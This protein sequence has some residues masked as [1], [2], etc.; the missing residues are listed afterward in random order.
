MAIPWNNNRLIIALAAAPGIAVVVLAAILFPRTASYG[1]ADVLPA[2]RTLLYMENADTQTIDRLGFLLPVLHTMT[3]VG[4]DAAAALIRHDDGSAHWLLFGRDASGNPDMRAANPATLTL[5]G[6][7]ARLRNDAGFR[8]L[9][10]GRPGTGSWIY[11]RDAQEHLAL[12]DTLQQPVGPLAIAATDDDMRIMWQA[13]TMAR[14]LSAAFGDTGSNPVVFRLQTGDAERALGDLAGMLNG[15]TMLAYEAA[16]RSWFAR[17]FGTDLSLAYDLAPLVRG[18]SSVTVVQTGSGTHALLEAASDRAGILLD[19]LHAGATASIGGAQHMDRTFDENF[20]IRHVR[21][22]T[23]TAS[24]SQELNGWL[25]QSTER[26]GKGVYSALKGER[27]MLSTDEQLLRTAMDTI[28]AP[29]DDGLPGMTVAR[30]E[31]RGDQARTLL[32]TGLPGEELPLP[33]DLLSS[34]LLRWELVRSGNLSVLRA[35]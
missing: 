7:G 28:A 16:L 30:G 18:Q 23:E 24:S 8:A 20:R 19:A 1:P 11:V 21:A 34:P 6:T 13:D 15:R 9:A 2:E 29:H 27:F 31:L 17:T 32:Q 10:Q 33:P 12:P 35:Y 3:D 5:I 25:L 26:D 4:V 22:G 14:P